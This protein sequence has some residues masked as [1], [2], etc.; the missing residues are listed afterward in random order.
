MKHSKRIYHL[1]VVAAVVLMLAAVVHA[2]DAGP[3]N[4]NT[5]TQSEIEALPGIGKKGAAKIIANRPYG[6]ADELSKAGLSA[7]KIA[8]LKDRV[9]FEGGA[10]ASAPAAAASAAAPAAAPS[11]VAASK[12]TSKSSE[13]KRAE[14]A[15]GGAVAAQSPPQSGMVWVNSKTK[16]YHTEGDR[17]YGK[18]K[19]GKWMT[20]ADAVKAGYRKSKRD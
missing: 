11:H 1:G 10:A 9:T 20:E 8:K 2:A 5:A 17:Y 12:R 6:S 16:I 7:K 19:S 14:A 15:E 18:T 3:V 13:T 4:L